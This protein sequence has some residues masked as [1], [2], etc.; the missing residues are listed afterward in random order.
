VLR[1]KSLYEPIITMAVLTRYLA[2]CQRSLLPAEGNGAGDNYFC[3]G[4]PHTRA[5]HWNAK[6]VLM[7]N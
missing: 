5:A 1:A 3:A 4:M 6:S 7:V 2:I